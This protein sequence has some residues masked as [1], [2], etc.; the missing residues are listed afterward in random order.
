MKKVSVENLKFIQNYKNYL[1]I[2]QKHEFEIDAGKR[3]AHVE[4][5]EI[6]EFHVMFSEKWRINVYYQVSQ[7]R[8]GNKNYNEIKCNNFSNLIYNNK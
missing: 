5:S 2:V 8:V 6:L 1:E 3:V 7:N 4:F